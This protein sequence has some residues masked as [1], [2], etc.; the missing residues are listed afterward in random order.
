MLTQS[1]SGVYSDAVNMEARRVNPISRR[2]AQDEAPGS[3]KAQLNAS[4]AAHSAALLSHQW[5]GYGFYHRS[6]RNLIIHAVAVPLF[7]LG[8]VTLFAALARGA[9][10]DSGIAIGLMGASLIVQGRAHRAEPNPPEPF[11]SPV[12][13]VT[14]LLA[15]QWIS[16]PRFLLSGRWRAAVREASA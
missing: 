7:L 13:A 14:R 11:T 10:I 8:N 6:R 15:E 5:E 9:W 3:E 12:N 4:S 2:E 1:T 16:F